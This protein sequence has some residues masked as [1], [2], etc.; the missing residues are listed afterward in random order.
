MSQTV[1]KQN[2]EL[3]NTDS[4][5]TESP[6]LGEELDKSWSGLYSRWKGQLEADF[7]TN[8]LNIIVFYLVASVSLLGSTLIAYADVSMQVSGQLGILTMIA[9]LATFILGAK[10][11]ISDMNV[12]TLIGID[13]F[14]ILALNPIFLPM[15]PV[16][17][18]HFYI[19]KKGYDWLNK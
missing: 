3:S 16:H 15:L 7:K 9:F 2:K 6:E 14:A 4:E 17:I 8:S 12:Y 13:S 1:Q 19:M 5:E 11:K 18:I 10:N